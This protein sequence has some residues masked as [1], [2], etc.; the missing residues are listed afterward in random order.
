MH[1]SLPECPKGTKKQSKTS[2]YDMLCFVNSLVEEYEQW[3]NGVEFLV[4]QKPKV[5]AEQSYLEW[6]QSIQFTVLSP[7]LGAF[8][9]LL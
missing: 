2:I 7:K 4:T 3:K 8:F 6:E 9:E 1:L 5:F